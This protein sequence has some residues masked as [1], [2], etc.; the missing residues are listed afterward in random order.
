MQN[1]TTMSNVNLDSD[2]FHTDACIK[3]YIPQSS[4]ESFP[5]CSPVHPVY[6]T[7]YTEL[8]LL[9]ILSWHPNP[10]T[11]SQF[12]GI[13]IRWFLATVNDG[14]KRL[15]DKCMWP[16]FRNYTIKTFLSECHWRHFHLSI[17]ILQRLHVWFVV[18]YIKRNVSSGPW[19]YSYLGHYK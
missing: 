17:D 10:Q 11:F 15:F 18:C 13:Q 3:T 7:H 6:Y 8:V 12:V 16:I 9:Q 1:N 19:R 2:H 5:E 14:L 4:T